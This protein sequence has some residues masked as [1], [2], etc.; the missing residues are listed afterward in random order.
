MK[1][2]STDTIAD[3]RELLRPET[4]WERVQGREAH[5]LGLVARIRARSEPLAL[6]YLALAVL[7]R[8]AAVGV[9]ALQAVDALLRER[10]PHEVA[11]LIDGSRGLDHDIAGTRLTAWYRIARWEAER[12]R[13]IG[14]TADAL[15]ALLSGHGNGHIREAAIGLL[16]GSRAPY[17]IPALRLRLNDWVAEVRLAA[18]RAIEPYLETGDLASLVSY[19]PLL[20][21]LRRCGR[22]DH[23]QLLHRLRVRMS[24]PEARPLLAAGCTH[25]DRHVRWWCFLVRATCE[26]AATFRHTMLASGDLAMRRH[27]AAAILAEAATVDPTPWLERLLGDRCTRVRRDGL[28]ALVAS[29]GAAALGRMRGLLTDR[30]GTVR[31]FARFYVGK[32]S[33]ATAIPTLLRARVAGA[34]DGELASCLAGLGDV[35]VIGDEGLFA[36]H[37]GHRQPAVRRFALLGLDRVLPLTQC[38]PFIAALRDASPRVRRAAVAALG[39]RWEALPVDALL[40]RFFRGEC[41]ERAG[42]FAAFAHLLPL[43][44]IGAY[45]AI[46]AHDEDA[47]QPRADQ[48]LRRLCA[49]GIDGYLR[50]ASASPS[51]RR[52]A[53]LLPRVER[54]LSGLVMAHVRALIGDARWPASGQW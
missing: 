27:V 9:A 40:E 1:T 32:W 48:H 36:A 43:E 12:W 31:E 29:S 42:V 14:P 20:E 16:A 26:D 54:E 6:R 46:I 30:N 13:G 24:A 3:L 34:N 25:P 22:G 7:D 28:L 19:L 50:I 49:A 23:G 5:L 41:D 4:L 52:I 10:T 44:R 47:W 8:H 17:V 15:F 33:D 37:L 35:A 18:V 53:G 38:G 11:R 45:L 51:L 21:E 39:R 2:L